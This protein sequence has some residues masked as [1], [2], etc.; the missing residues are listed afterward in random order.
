MALD[1]YPINTLTPVYS[2]VR[3][4]IDGAFDFL[5]ISF[6]SHIIISYHLPNSRVFP[7]LQWWLSTKV[8]DRLWGQDWG[9]TSESTCH[10]VTVLLWVTQFPFH[11][12]GAESQNWLGSGV[13]ANACGLRLIHSWCHLIRN[14][15]QYSCCFPV[16]L[17]PWTP[18]SISYL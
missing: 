8:V 5:D 12:I 4:S 6:D 1:K 16:Y 7:F 2:L 10:G 13:W 3:G 18:C 14:T 9:I 15:K 17:A 11:L